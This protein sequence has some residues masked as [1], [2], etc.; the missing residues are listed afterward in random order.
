MQTGF[1]R[2]LDTL[3]RLTIPSELRR[4]FDMDIHDPVE[5]YMDKNFIY[6]RKYEP[7]DIFTG[8]MSELIDYKGKKVSKSSIE[9]MAQ[10]AGIIEPA[11]LEA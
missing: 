11:V 3:G 8:E 9:E 5:I 6:L 4:G 10:I 1:V 2:K 7:F